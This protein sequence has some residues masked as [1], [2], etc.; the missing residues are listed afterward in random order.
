MYQFEG[1]ECGRG[2]TVEL[3]NV[4]IWRYKDVSMRFYA[5]WNVGGML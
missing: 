4:I 5:Q 2:Y 3:A 1:K